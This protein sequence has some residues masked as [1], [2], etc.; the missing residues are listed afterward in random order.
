MSESK[1]FKFLKQKAE[2][3]NKWREE[4]PDI[5]PD[6]TK[7][8]LRG[9]NLCGVNLSGARLKE[10]NLKD[11]NLSVADVRRANHTEG[12]LIGTDF[13]WADLS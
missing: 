4:N 8:P 6:L 7:Y 10:V 5:K 9:E 3:W 2:F 11:I 13:R 1:Y 12:N